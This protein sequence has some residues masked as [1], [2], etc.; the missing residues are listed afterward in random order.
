MACCICV[1]WEFYVMT[2]NKANRA[3]GQMGRISQICP[4]SLICLQVGDEGF[5]VVGVGAFKENVTVAEG[6]GVEVGT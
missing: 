6:V 3:T 1:Y 4:I 5:H 2:I